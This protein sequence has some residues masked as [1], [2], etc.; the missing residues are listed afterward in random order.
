M[1]KSYRGWVAVLIPPLGVL[2]VA[3]LDSISP[4]ARCLSHPYRL[5]AATPLGLCS[6]F[7]RPCLVE[8]G[9]VKWVPGTKF[10]SSHLHTQPSCQLSPWV[11]R[12]LSPSPGLSNSAGLADS[13]HPR[14][15]H[16][17]IRIGGTRANTMTTTF[18]HGCWRPN[19]GLHT[20]GKHVTS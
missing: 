10:S 16:L 5:P 1:G 15:L 8:S 2:E 7:Q 11:L 20:A 14:D 18:L 6:A 13:Q 9:L 3:S 4:T 12:H 17:S 19:A